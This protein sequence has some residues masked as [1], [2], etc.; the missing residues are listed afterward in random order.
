MSSSIDDFE[1]GDLVVATLNNGSII[2]GTVD[3]ID[4]LYPG[5]CSVRQTGTNTYWWVDQQDL[6]LDLDAMFPFG[7]T[8][9]SLDAMVSTPSHNG[10]EVVDNQV[11]G[12]AFRYC[13]DCKEEV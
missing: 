9:D 4:T 3:T 13:R 6:I 8:G 1:V 7:G 5:K 2:R 12:K 11:M 10:H